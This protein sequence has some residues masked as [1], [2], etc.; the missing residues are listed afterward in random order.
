MKRVG[1]ITALGTTVAICVLAGTEPGDG[2]SADREIEG[3]KN[4]INEL[5]ARVLLLETRLNRLESAADREKQEPKPPLPLPLQF[6]SIA[7]PPSTDR[8]QPDIWGERQINGW[9]FYVV[10]CHADPSLSVLPA[11]G[12]R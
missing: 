7:I 11:A 10:P 8:P 5:Q 4:Q 2:N 6:P 1:L 12:S 3:L 9:T